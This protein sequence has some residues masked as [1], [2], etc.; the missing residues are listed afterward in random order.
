MDD[1]NEW[2]ELT[3]TMPLKLGMKIP[4]HKY[5][6]EKQEIRQDGTL[7]EPERFTKGTAKN[8]TTLDIIGLGLLTTFRYA[9]F[10]GMLIELDSRREKDK[11]A[12]LHTK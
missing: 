5:S 7:C 1:K 11:D 9:W 8:S 3:E 6:V 12:E 2:F 10:L 4:Q